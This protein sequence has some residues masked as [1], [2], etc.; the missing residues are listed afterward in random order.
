MKKPVWFADEIVRIS[1]KRKIT[2]IE[3]ERAILERIEELA[4]KTAGNLVEAYAAYNLE[5]VD[6]IDEDF[7]VELYMKEK[8]VT[9][10]VAR[11]MFASTPF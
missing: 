4:E 9:E 11:A 6:N 1:K 5:R 3:A 8:G 10:D 7:Y 2:A